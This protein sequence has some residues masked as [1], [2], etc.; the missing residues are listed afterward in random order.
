MPKGNL[1]LRISDL[2]GG[3]V[4]G[5]VEIE[6][7]RLPG[8]PGVGGQ[9]MEISVNMG[10]A[11]E[12]IVTGITCRGGPGTLYKVSVSAPHYRPYSFF[13]SI[14]ES[15]DNTASDDVTFWVKPGEVAEIR[16]P[17]F[18]NL[19]DRLVAILTNADMHAQKA[20]DRD[21][22]GASGPSLYD[23]L[24]P[25][26][27]GCLLN[28]AR[29]ASHPSSNDCLR[30]V[31]GMLLCRQDR[32][33]ALVDPLLPEQL[34]QS[35]LYKSAPENLHEP[36]PGFVL[37]EGSFKTRDAHANLQVTFMRHVETEA[38]AA[39]IDIDESSGIEHGFE[40]IRNAVF[41]TRTNPYLIHE[42]LLSAD[43][44]RRSLDPGYGFVF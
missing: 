9:A 35:P 19:G 42:F 32:F 40:V 43:P 14:R 7:N 38:L 22:L 44:Q 27:K 36:L 1:A 10:S 17:R 21:L 31:K 28:L 15:L 5:P 2:G 24:G 33:F 25:L 26:R 30:S 8:E 3:P 20:E 6:L 16:A 39:D 41:R 12:L 29:K 11:T 4:T 23:A 18:Q 37:S 13:Q 34:R